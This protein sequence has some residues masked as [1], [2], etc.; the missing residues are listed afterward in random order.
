MAPIDKLFSLQQGWQILFD[1][2]R[3]YQALLGNKKVEHV[4]QEQRDY[5]L[6]YV[7]I[8]TEVQDLYAQ[9]MLIEEFTGKYIQEGGGELS[10]LYIEFTSAVDWLANLEIGKLT[11]DERGREYLRDFNLQTLND[12]MYQYQEDDNMSMLSGATYN[13]FGGFGASV[14]SGYRT[15][16]RMDHGSINLEQFK[17]PHHS[18]RQMNK[19]QQ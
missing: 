1:E 14:H 19:L 3:D 18:K 5:I 7:L 2:I 4:G 15:E 12:R 11:N 13:M 9:R 17:N 10:K 6:R 16:S 8:K